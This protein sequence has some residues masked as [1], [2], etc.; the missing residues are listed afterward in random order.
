MR[1]W[2]KFIRTKV[3]ERKISDRQYTLNFSVRRTVHDIFTQNMKKTRQAKNRKIRN[4][5]I[6]KPFFSKTVMFWEKFL[7]TKVVE[8]EISD[9]K[10]TLHFSL[11]RTVCEIFEENGKKN[12][13]LQ[14]SRQKDKYPSWALN[15]ESSALSQQIC[16][17]I[18]RALSDHQ[19]NILWTCQLDWSSYTGVIALESQQKTNKQTNKSTKNLG[20][21]Q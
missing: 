10:N 14:L 19:L 11:G 16:T 13:A 4:L 18:Y 3:V 6:L 9:N 7:R 8:F 12:W 15:G 5:L 20:W 17:K 1:F 21:L 2:E